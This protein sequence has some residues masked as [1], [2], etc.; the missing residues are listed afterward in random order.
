MKVPE[1]IKIIAESN[2]LYHRAFEFV[3]PYKAIGFLG[4]LC[5]LG[6]S[7]CELYYPQAIKDITDKKVLDTKNVE[8]LEC[9][10]I[11]VVAVFLARGIF[12]WGQQRTMSYVGQKVILDI[13]DKLVEKINSRGI[14]YFDKNKSGS[15]MSIVTNDAALLKNTMTGDMLSLIAGM[16]T[17]I[18]SVGKMLL[19]DWKL[20]LIVLLIFLPVLGILDLFTKKLSEA[21]RK[22]QESAAELNAMLKEIVDSQVVV[23][24]FAREKHETQLYHNK[25]LHNFNDNY[26]CI[27][28]MSLRNPLIEFILACSL[29]LVLLIG[30]HRVING[31]ITS[32]DFLAFLA[33]VLICIKPVKSVSEVIGNIQKTTPAAKRVFDFLDA[34]EEITDK[35]NAKE[36]PDNITEV[37]FKNVTFGYSDKEE[38][39]HNFNFKTESGKVIAFVGPSGAGKSTIARLLPRFYDVKA[40]EITVNNIDIRS[41]RIESLREQIGI[42]PQETA[43]FNRSVR[44][45]I[46]YGRLDATED[47]VITAAKAANAHDFIMGLPQGYDTILGDRGSNI[48]GGQRQR[49]AIARAILKNPQILILDEATSAL[50]NESEKKV[51][52]ALERLMVG[53]TSFVIAHRLS[54]IKNADKI[55]VLD[56]G[57]LV[58]EGT[59][60]ELIARNGLYADL[61]SKQDNKNKSNK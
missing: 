47:A 26:K 55:L 29:A 5:S 48:S 31:N 49:I 42:V 60:D 4:I 57:V 3:K 9:I 25:N 1:S 39:L 28:Y 2:R 33:Y 46:L 22:I 12:R 10:A 27:Q 38:V 6:A 16:A 8:E 41:V 34:D 19:S 43:L 35:E 24:S 45:N 59:H 32:G 52:E 13:S 44:D 11:M 40:G 21:G 51:Q 56:K 23:K 50:D 15:I 53:R 7:A 61:W 20:S 36:L 54:T 58:E 18:G 37:E 30:G 17:V 14:S